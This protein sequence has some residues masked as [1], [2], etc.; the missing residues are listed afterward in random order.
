[1]RGLAN[2]FIPGGVNEA[3]SSYLLRAFVR[4]DVY[5][6][7]HKVFN[8]K[9]FTLFR[10]KPGVTGLLSRIKFTASM[11]LSWLFFYTFLQKE[12]SNMFF[13]GEN[14]LS[15]PLISFFLPQ[16][17]HSNSAQLLFNSVTCF[18]FV[19]ALEYA[20][21]LKVAFLSFFIPSLLSNEVLLGMI[22]PIKF[23]KPELW[24][25]VFVGRDVGGSLGVFGCLGALAF[26]SSR[27][28]GILLA[29]A[30][31]VIGVSIYFSDLQQLNH[32]IALALGFVF[33]RMIM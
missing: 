29:T 5:R 4:M 31:C 21:G 22:I 28:M 7:I 15:H 6:W 18:L 25:A 23:I 27:R 3:L 10:P 26:Y 20:L 9:V 13:S 8:F 16:F 1:M 19:G 32:L 14:F 30:L 12:S 33:A 17:Y 2:A 11:I 24:S